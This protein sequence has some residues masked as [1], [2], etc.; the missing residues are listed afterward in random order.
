MLPACH[1]AQRDKRYTAGAIAV[2]GVQF[3]G[4]FMHN[5]VKT[6][7]IKGILNIKPV[8][9]DWPLLP[10]L[11][12][13]HNALIVHQPNIIFPLVIDDE[14]GGINQHFMEAIQPLKAE[15]KHRQTEEQG[16]TRAFERIQLKTLQRDEAFLL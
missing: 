12:R 4:Y 13:L 2:A 6:G 14:R 10:A 9:D 16:D 3:M 1:F 5:Q 7:G 8:Q 11:T 15:L